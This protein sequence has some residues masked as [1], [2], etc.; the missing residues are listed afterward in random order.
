M[1]FILH[2]LGSE[3]I[4]FSSRVSEGLLRI[5]MA[6]HE[7]SNVYLNVTPFAQTVTFSADVAN[8]SVSQTTPAASAAPNIIIFG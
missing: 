5:N 2:I 1:L 8:G 6:R 7:H 4:H 3:C